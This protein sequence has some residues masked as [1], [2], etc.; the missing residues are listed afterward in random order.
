VSP[1]KIK[2]P[3]KKSR[4]AALRR[5]IYFRVKRLILKVVVIS[6]KLRFKSLMRVAFEQGKRYAGVWEEQ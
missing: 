5:G 6:G 3:S 1:L 4:Q 2:M